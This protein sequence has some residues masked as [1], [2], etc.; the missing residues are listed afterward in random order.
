MPAFEEEIEATGEELSLAEL[1]HE[2]ARRR[3]KLLGRRDGPYLMFE[4]TSD[5]GFYTRS[6]NLE[7][8]CNYFPIGIL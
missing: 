3:E 4:I 2:E 6:D 7:G 1:E 8:T 5:D